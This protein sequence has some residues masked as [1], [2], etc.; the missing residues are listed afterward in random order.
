[1]ADIKQVVAKNIIELRKKNKMTQNELAEKLNYSDNAVSRWERAEVTPSIETIEQIAEVFNVPIASI[2]EDNARTVSTAQDKKQILNKLAVILIFFSLVWLIATI[3]FAYGKIIF[4][5]NLWQV[6]AWAVPASCLVLYPFNYYWGKYI[7][8]FV[9]LSVFQWTLLACFYL[10]FL[11]YNM[12]LT[13]I[14]GV[15][16]Q[17]ALCIW[18][19]I[20]PKSMHRK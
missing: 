3:T 15:P 19:F 13:F 5:V 17:V 2:L 20:K 14:I 18:A 9:I 8:K 16:I 7:W 10:Q 12:W 1:M 4:N 11:E 6:F